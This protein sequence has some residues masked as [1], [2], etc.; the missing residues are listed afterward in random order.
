[1][2]FDSRTRSCRFGLQ[3]GRVKLSP[4]TRFLDGLCFGG[5]F[6][7]PLVLG[8]WSIHGR[9]GSGLLGGVKSASNMEV[10]GGGGGGGGCYLWNMQEKDPPV[11]L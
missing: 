6:L 2:I 5:V 11:F 1:M 10:G 7:L 3:L 9:S 4:L 8:V